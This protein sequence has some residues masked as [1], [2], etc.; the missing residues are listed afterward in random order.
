MISR[1][2]IITF[3]AGFETFHALLHAY[4]GT[5]KRTRLQGHPVEE[6]GIKVTPRFHMISAVANGAV[7]IALGAWALARR[8]AHSSAV[9]T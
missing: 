9:A 4:L 3:L 5:S 7:A 1:T 8:P 2:R 6:L